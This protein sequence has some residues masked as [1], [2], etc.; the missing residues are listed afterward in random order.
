MGLLA[1]L[2]GH[3]KL[4]PVD[5]DADLGHGCVRL[6]AP[7]VCYSSCASTPLIVSIAWSIRCAISRLAVSSPRDAGRRVIEFAGEL[8]A[9]GTE[10]VDLRQ[11]RLVVAVEFAAP[12]G[13]GFER[14]KRER[15][16]PARDSDGIGVA[17]MAIRY[18]QRCALSSGENPA[19][20][21]IYA[22]KL[23]SHRA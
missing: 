7:M 1:I 9:I 3:A 10:R 13:R 4:P 23:T 6:I 15:Q 14:V 5:R 8:R 22:R 2:A 12:L 18:G 17:H 11:Q 20:A 16:A 19:T 21:T